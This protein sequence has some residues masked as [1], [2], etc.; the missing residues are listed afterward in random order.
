M[1]INGRL[2]KCNDCTS[3]ARMKLL[4]LGELVLNGSNPTHPRLINILPNRNKRV[5]LV[6]EN[7]KAMSKK[8]ASYL[9]G[10]KVQKYKAQIFTEHGDG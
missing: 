7:G 1:Q 6:A 3:V 2:H 8:I 9:N 10:L 5:T 4:D